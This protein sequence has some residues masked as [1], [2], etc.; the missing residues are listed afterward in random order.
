M[1]GPRLERGLESGMGVCEA[2]V[3]TRGRAW[4]AQSRHPGPYSPSFSLTAVTAS[5]ALPRAVVIPSAMC[6][7]ASLICCTADS[8]MWTWV[9]VQ[10]WPPRA[11]GLARN[12]WGSAGSCICLLPSR[13]MDTWCTPLNPFP[14]A[15][16]AWVA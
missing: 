16:R 1:L 3:A 2:V 12:P 7:P 6:V 4:I 14:G 5:P 13:G 11:R 9:R 10:G 15:L 8:C